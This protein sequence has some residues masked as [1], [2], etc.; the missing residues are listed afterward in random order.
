MSDMGKAVKIRI[1]TAVFLFKHILSQRKSAPAV[2]L[3][4]AVVS[5]AVKKNSHIAV[6]KS[7]F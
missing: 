3:H 6:L 7:R 2:P 5:T 4:N 1:T